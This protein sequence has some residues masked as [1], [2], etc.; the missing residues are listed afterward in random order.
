MRRYEREG[1]EVRRY[2]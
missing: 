1:K 2:E